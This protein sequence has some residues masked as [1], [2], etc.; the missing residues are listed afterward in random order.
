MFLLGIIMF[1]FVSNFITCISVKDQRYSSKFILNSIQNIY[2]IF[3]L[4]FTKKQMRIMWNYSP[5][6]KNY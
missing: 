1:S 5:E 3:I 6:Q 4:N 2:I